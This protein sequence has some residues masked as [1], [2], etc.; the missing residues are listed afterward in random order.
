MATHI[1]RYDFRSI[2][3]IMYADIA[4]SPESVA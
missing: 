2:L 4:S 1:G 3:T